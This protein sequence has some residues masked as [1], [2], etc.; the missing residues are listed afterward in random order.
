MYRCIY[1]YIYIYIEREREMYMYI[2]SL[3]GPQVYAQLN[4]AAGKEYLLI[5]M[6]YK[7]GVE[8]SFEVEV[9]SD[10]PLSFSKLGEQD[11]YERRRDL[12]IDLYIGRSIEI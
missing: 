10:Q 8:S 2:S 9:Y 6:T 7:K 12:V 1:I 11:A 3:S 4:V 5:P